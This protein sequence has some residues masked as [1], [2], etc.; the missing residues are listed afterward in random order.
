MKY[1]TAITSDAHMQAVAH[2]LRRDRQE[3]L[4]FAIW[5]PSQDAI[6]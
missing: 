4:C 2:L 5:F 6:V 1:S 3:D